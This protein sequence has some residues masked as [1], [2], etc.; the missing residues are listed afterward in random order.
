MFLNFLKFASTLLCI[1]TSWE[2]LV[3]IYSKQK[4]ISLGLGLNDWGV[5]STADIQPKKLF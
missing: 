2:Y 3:G 1:F 5:T 4:N